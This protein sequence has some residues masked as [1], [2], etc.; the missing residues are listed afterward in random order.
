M[1]NF[2]ESKFPSSRYVFDRL[3]NM[4]RVSETLPEIFDDVMRK[5]PVLLHKVPFLEWIVIC[6]I[7]WM[8]FVVG[9]LCGWGMEGDV[10]EKDINVVDE[11]SSTGVS[12]P[13]GNINTARLLEGFEDCNMG[14]SPS[15]GLDRLENVMNQIENESNMVSSAASSVSGND[16][17]QEDSKK[18]GLRIKCSYK[19][20]LEKGSPE[21]GSPEK[22]AQEN[23]AAAD[24]DMND[25][26]YDKEAK[27]G[28]KVISKKQT[29]KKKSETGM[30]VN[31]KTAKVKEDPILELF[32]T[33]W[34]TPKKEGQTPTLLGSRSASYN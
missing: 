10:K 11:S 24:H 21:K 17:D 12:C 7:E 16:A 32:E 9:V 5:F 14:I 26:G 20:A 27:G 22:G 6:V 23:G 19:E 25:H 34:Q 18:S 13:G 15:S 1:E 4:A 3:D 29:K 28:S 8:N 2:I 33:G 31:V 30:C